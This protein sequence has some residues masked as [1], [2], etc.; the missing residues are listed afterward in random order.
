MA[1]YKS[2]QEE[3]DRN[4]GA[5]LLRLWDGGQGDLAAADS[6]ARLMQSR[7]RGDKD[8]ARENMNSLNT[9]G[10]GPGHVPTVHL[11]LHDFYK[12]GWGVDADPGK[13]LWHL[14]RAIDGGSITAQWFLGS[15]LLGDEALAP[16]LPKDADRGLAIL[17]EVVNHPT[18]HSSAALARGSA[19]SY[20][21][22]NFTIHEVSREDRELIDA[23]A[24]D[25]TYIRSWD[26]VHLARFYAG[27]A[28][29]N[30]YAGPEYE[31]S[32]QLLIKGSESFH[33]SARNACNE[34]L[35]AW[36]VRPLPPRPKTTAEKAVTV[37][38]TTAAVGGIGAIMWV[39]SIIGMALLAMTAMISA[40]T[41][42]IILG[43][44]GIA[45][46]VK[47]MRR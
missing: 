10:A 28:T 24:A 45:F 40:V 20:L 42:P 21:I 3:S 22:K 1:R 32:R 8:I 13:S 46:I 9:V 25:S 27:A 7:M 30:N 14:E 33:E 19:A 18:D 15:Y 38:K 35:D 5:T 4:L 39:W 34:Q 37:A 11:T 29:D 6:H 12:R 17:R 23:Y 16:V 26:Y 43:V 41:I 36:G 44:F 31:K 2:E 47:L